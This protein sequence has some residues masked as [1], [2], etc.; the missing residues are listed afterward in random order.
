M[1]ALLLCLRSVDF[2]GLGKCFV[3]DSYRERKHGKQIRGCEKV[4][5]Y[6]KT[7]NFSQCLSFLNLLFYSKNEVLAILLWRK[8]AQIKKEVS[9]PL[10]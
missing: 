2:P 8:A 4:V 5:S 10:L 6:L 9:L 7:T 3:E 1:S